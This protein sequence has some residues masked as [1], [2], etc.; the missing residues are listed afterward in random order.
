MLCLCLSLQVAVLADAGPEAPLGADDRERG[1]PRDV[2]ERAAP[3]ALPGQCPGYDV[4]PGGG[5]GGGGGGVAEDPLGLGQVGHEGGGD[6]AEEGE[7]Q[8]E[9]GEMRHGKMEGACERKCSFAEQDR[10]G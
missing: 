7:L 6:E 10:Q 5:R 9:G 4:Q 2:Q 1:R 8:G 3:L